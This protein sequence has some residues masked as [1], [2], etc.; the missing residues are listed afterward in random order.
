MSA[1]SADPT[2]SQ[3]LSASQPKT[4]PDIPKPMLGL[5][6]H[7]YR[8]TECT[9]IWKENWYTFLLPKWGKTYSCKLGQGYL[10]PVGVEPWQRPLSRI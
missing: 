10:M 5:L 9:Y 8:T 4:T 7:A 3:Q 6:G 1:E 2:M